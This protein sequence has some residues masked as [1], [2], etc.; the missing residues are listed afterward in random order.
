MIPM[1]FGAK[2]LWQSCDF[3]LSLFTLVHQK[4]EAKN[5]ILT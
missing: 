2:I 3:M 1:D 4:N 5:I